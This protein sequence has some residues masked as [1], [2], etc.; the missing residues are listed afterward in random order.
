MTKVGPGITNVV[1]E[2]LG[3]MIKA[4]KEHWKAVECAVGY[5]LNEPHNGLVL[6]NCK[7][8]KPY[9]Y[10]DADYTSNE[11]DQRSISSR[12]SMLGGMIIEWK[13]HTVSL[14]SCKSKYIAYGEACQEAVFLAQ[15]IKEIFKHQTNSVVYSCYSDNQGA[16]FLVKNCQV[17]QQTK[18]IDIHQHFVRDL[19][20]QK[21]VLGVFVRSKNNMADSATKRRSSLWHMQPS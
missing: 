17:G 1:R 14:S 4:T 6:R 9:I 20:K 2:L 16:L 10:A 19:Q 18:H 11:D 21:Q 7:N 12:V 5:I 13:Q 15:L 3:Q 8:F